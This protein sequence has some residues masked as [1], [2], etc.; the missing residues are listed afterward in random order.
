MRFYD[1]LQLGPEVLKK[2]IRQAD[3]PKSKHMLQLAMIT[4]SLLIVFLATALIGPVGPIFGAQ[5]SCMA[6][7]IFCLVL[8]IRFVD[9]GY[10]MSDALICLAI[11]FFILLVMPIL[12]VSSSPIIGA[13]I[14]FI[15]IFVLMTITSDRP[16]MGNG[17][18]F[19]FA[20]ILMVGNPVSDILFWK[21]ALL[22][23]IGYIICALIYFKN[24]RNKNTDVRFHSLA[25]K[26]HLSI[27]KCRWQFQ[28]ALGVSL[29]FALCSVLK[30]ARMMWAGFACASMFGCYSGNIPTKVNEKFGQR[31]VG[32]VLGSA[33]FYVIF[34]LVP[35]QFHFV[36]GPLGG[37][38]LGFCA[39]YK[40]KTAMNCLG[41]LM[42]ATGIYGLEYSVILRILNN[43]FGAAFGFAFSLLYHKLITSRFDSDEK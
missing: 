28:M 41:A 6:V 42:M 8:G 21:R 7:V 33:A 32:V 13:L 18:L 39:E 10:C 9:F 29:L 40:Y 16:E 36:M 17:G 20:Y 34:K 38:L 31:L 30:V 37:I 11:S 35:V 27:K 19:S 23:L 43:F 1:A 3:T 24:H 25:S 5:N 15:A 2:Q 14:H 12:A 26:F 4:R 22:T